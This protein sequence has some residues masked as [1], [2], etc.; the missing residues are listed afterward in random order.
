[1]YT[2][3]KMAVLTSYDAHPW[4]CAHPRRGRDCDWAEVTVLRCRQSTLIDVTTQLHPASPY[5]NADRARSG[6]YRINRVV[7]VR[8]KEMADLQIIIPLP[9][10]SGTTSTV[11]LFLC[12]GWP[13]MTQHF[14]RVVSVALLLLLLLL[15]MQRLR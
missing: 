9:I 12:R 13:S 5:V 14:L 6:A 2:V 7:C 15:Y 3:P 1:M 10:N 11:L 4:S 8:N